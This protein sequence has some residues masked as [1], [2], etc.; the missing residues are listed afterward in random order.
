MPIRAFQTS[1]ARQHS[2]PFGTSLLDTGEIRFRIWAPSAKKVELCL[3]QDNGNCCLFPMEADD[4]REFTHTSDSAR[5]GCRYHFKIDDDLLVPDPASRYQPEDVHGPSEVIDPSRFKWTDGDWKGR[6]WEEAIIYELHVG[7]FSPQG[8]FAGVIEK[9]PHLVECG[10]TAIELMPVCDFPGR[11]NWGYDGVL[12][13]APDSTYGTPDDLKRLVEAAHHAGL[14]VLLDVV[15]NH[16]GPQGNYLYVYARDFF[17]DA[18]KTPWGSAINYDGKNSRRVRDFFLHNAL[19]WL[20]EYHVDG[21]RLDA[22]HAIFDRSQP[23]IL[24][25]IAA[26]VASGP[27]AERY[28]HLVLENDDNISRYLVRDADMKPRWYTAQWNDDFHHSLH[29]LTTGET[30]GYY[31]DYTEENSPFSTTEHAARS[32]AF[33][34]SY[35]GQC[36]Q[37]RDGKVRGE[38]TQDLPPTAFVPFLQNHD[39]IGNRPFG[40]R[41]SR[42]IDDSSLRAATAILLLA[43]SPPLFYMGDEFKAASPFLY[44]CDLGP[45]LAPLVREGRRNE[46]AKFPAFR[47]P[48]TRETIPDPGAYET[49]EKSKLNWQELT[50]EKHKEWYSFFRQLIATRKAEIIPRVK[51]IVSARYHHWDSGALV[52]R[53]T[54]QDGSAICLSA[55]LSAQPF[56][57]SNAQAAQYR[58][59]VGNSRVIYETKGVFSSAA[60]ENVLMP[61]TAVWAI[62]DH[63]S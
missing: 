58:E 50:S 52:V 46:F 57:L 22:V 27:G 30:S 63:A 19:Y 49:F 1:I 41:L 43:P 39:Q 54:L 29:L 40:E 31:A 8:T 59:F 45:E 38:P 15:Y 14:M 35:Q 23:H 62:E 17:S 56:S 47:D 42:L 4:S 61:W 21:L 53:W 28:V 34:F 55:N 37:Y 7:T 6:P 18:H 44:F 24:E 2:M 5:I 13:F 60:K 20:N 3:Y 51:M 25:E 48:A 16:F 26:A 12:P 10:I 32:L 11:C 36:S 33:G 9:L